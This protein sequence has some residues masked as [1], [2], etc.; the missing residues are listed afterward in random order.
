M[1]FLQHT[2]EFHKLLPVL[3]QNFGHISAS[4]C[5]TG[6]FSAL[7]NKSLLVSPFQLLWRCFCAAEGSRKFP[8]SQLVSYVCAILF[9]R[10]FLA[11]GPLCLSQPRSH[12]ITSHSVHLSGQPTSS[13]WWNNITLA[14]QNRTIAI[15]SD[16]RVDGAKSPEIPRKKG[17]RARKSQPEI[18]DR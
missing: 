1:I 9:F 7:I 8:G 12:A 13:T 3:V 6:N 15:A 5:Y 2:R 4:Q 17:F 18:A 16:F 10:D 14:H 11:P